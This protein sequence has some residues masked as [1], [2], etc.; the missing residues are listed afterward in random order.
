[1]KRQGFTILEV[2]A[3][4]GILATL[5]VLVAQVGYWSLRERQRTLEQHAALEIAEN[6]LEAARAQ[7]WIELDPTWAARQRIPGEWTD[8]LLQGKLSVRVEAEKSLMRSKRVTVTVTWQTE[9][10][11]PRKVELVGIFS[12]HEAPRTGEKR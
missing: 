5:M 10:V 8:I 11:L 7:A 1:M 9:P 12:A 4:L 6:T 2:V 3:A